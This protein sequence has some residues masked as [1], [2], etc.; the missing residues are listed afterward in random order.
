M[1]TAWHFNLNQKNKNGNNEGKVVR[2][3]YI[4]GIISYRSALRKDAVKKVFRLDPLE[5]LAE[6]NNMEKLKESRKTMSNSVL[7][8]V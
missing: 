6:L 5:E 1:L 7:V 2:R 8:E 3:F 4:G